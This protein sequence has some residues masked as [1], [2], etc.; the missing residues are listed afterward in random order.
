MPFDF[1]VAARAASLKTACDASASRHGIDRRSR[2][3]R[4][5]YIALEW[6]D[7]SALAILG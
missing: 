4:Q 7:F 6:S 2:D 3:Q 5:F 1:E